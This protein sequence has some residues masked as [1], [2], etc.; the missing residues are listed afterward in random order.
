MSKHDTAIVL[1]ADIAKRAKECAEQ[2]K[3]LGQ[4]ADEKVQKI[5]ELKV[6]LWEIIEEDPQVDVNSK[7]YNYNSI[8][9]KLTLVGAKDDVEDGDDFD[10]Q[11]MLQGLGLGG[12]E[13]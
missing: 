13:G 6:R 5:Q 8:K 4:E 2:M 11:A 7:I 10:I 9:H 1:A 12:G 3:K